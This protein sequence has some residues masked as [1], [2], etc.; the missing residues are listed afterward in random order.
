MEANANSEPALKTSHTHSPSQHTLLL[1]QVAITRTHTKLTR[2]SMNAARA[3]KPADAYTKCSLT[4]CRSCMDGL[5][6]VPPKRQQPVIRMLHPVIQSSL[7][8][9]IQ[10]PPAKLLIPAPAR[11]QPPTVHPCWRRCQGRSGSTRASQAEAVGEAA[12]R[13]SDPSPHP[14]TAVKNSGGCTQATA[15]H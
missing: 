13:T 9:H 8:M 12:H 10:A 14:R 6:S 15:A 5:L 7:S 11:A 3:T 4:R 1:V 2:T